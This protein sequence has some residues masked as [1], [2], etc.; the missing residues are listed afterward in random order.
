MQT[1]A[2]AQVLDRDS[3]HDRRLR[4]LIS[5][6]YGRRTDPAQP[7]VPDSK[8][9]SPSPEGVV[10]ASEIYAKRDDRR[11]TLAAVL[12]YRKTILQSSR[13]MS[14]IKRTRKHSSGAAAASRDKQESLQY[15]V[16]LL[17]SLYRR[18]D[19]PV[20]SRRHHCGCGIIGLDR[21]LIALTEALQQPRRLDKTSR[22]SPTG[23]SRN[24][25]GCGALT[26]QATT[27]KYTSS[28]TDS[29]GGGGCIKGSGTQLLGREEHDGKRQRSIFQ[30]DPLIK[31][32]KANIIRS[33]NSN[34]PTEQ[35]LFPDILQSHTT[36]NSPE[37]ISQQTRVKRRY[38]S[39]MRTQWE[40]K[41]T[42]PRGLPA[43]P[44]SP[45][46]RHKISVNI[47]LNAAVMR[48]E[49][50]SSED[51]DEDDRVKAR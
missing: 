4:K 28:R 26:S 20:S 11:S 17:T 19:S 46:I 43:L 41:D 18:I 48:R 3:E 27:N 31:I 25:H 2:A 38:P 36:N 45:G 51:E 33:N 1:Q 23:V 22:L 42:T 15:V 13:I 39:V 44:L 12:E 7:R 29:P 9:S 35:S 6:I 40:D 16:P 24:H 47:T 8:S 37:K 30:R 5:A 50:S 21:K 34:S 10:Q 14:R 32:S 49:Y